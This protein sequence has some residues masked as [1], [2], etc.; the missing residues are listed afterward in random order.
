M[1]VIE[2]GDPAALLRDDTG[3]AQG[4]AQRGAAQGFRSEMRTV[5]PDVRGLRCCAC[6]CIGSAS[7]S[8][9]T[10]S[11][12]ICCTRSATLRGST[13]SVLQVELLDALELG[14]GMLTM[15]VL[16]VWGRQIIKDLLASCEDEDGDDG[17]KKNSQVSSSLGTRV[18]GSNSASNGGAIHATNG[19]RL[20]ADGD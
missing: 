5:E 14:W 2:L 19:F 17:V 20:D 13:R 1:C 12:V 4:G 18:G 11:W 6:G 7:G 3:D 8:R 15:C 16:L 10:S 9:R